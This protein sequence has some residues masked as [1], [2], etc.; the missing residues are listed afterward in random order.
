MATVVKIW[1]LSTKPKIAIESQDWI[2]VPETTTRR[3]I[4]VFAM[5]NVHLS[6]PAQWPMSGLLNIL[7]KWAIPNP[8]ERTKLILI[9]AEVLKGFTVRAFLQLRIHFANFLRK[10][11][12]VMKNP[13]PGLA[14]L[15]RCARRNTQKSEEFEIL[16]LGESATV[17]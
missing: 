13:G 17:S 2:P 6:Y 10:G 7:Y 5:W 4:I 16:K 14:S 9:T 12:A 8:R 15:R 11:Q 1:K 3:D